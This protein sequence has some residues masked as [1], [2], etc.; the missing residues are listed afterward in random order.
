M[1]RAGQPRTRKRR[2]HTEPAAHASEQLIE[3][4]RMRLVGQ[5][6][7]HLLKVLGPRYGGG[8]AASQSSASA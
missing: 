5:L 1:S 8:K 2:A 4:R 3:T 7:N 6:L